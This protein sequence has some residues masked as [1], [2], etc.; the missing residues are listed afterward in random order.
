MS[1]Y[2]QF[3]EEYVDAWNRKD[4]D[5]LKTFFT[6]DVLYIDQAVGCHLDINT[7]EGF[8]NGFIGN[9]SEG[10]FVDITYVSENPEQ[11]KLVYEWDCGGTSKDGTKMFIQGVSMIEMRGNKIRRNTDYWDYAHSPKAKQQAA[12]AQQ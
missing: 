8:L 6:E 9:Y 3:L 10:F 7:V 4:V 11:E 12:Q 2:A 1:K 5:A